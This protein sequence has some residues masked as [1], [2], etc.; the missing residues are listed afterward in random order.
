MMIYRLVLGFLLISTIAL[1][2]NTPTKEQGKTV[3][4]LAGKQRMLTQKMSKEAL[5]II[6]GIEIEKNRVYLQET[7]T[8][9]DKRLHALK[10]GNR[11]LNIPKTEDKEILN[12]LTKE[13]KLWSLFKKFLNEII[14]GKVDKKILKAV[15]MA[16]MPLLQI[17]N[18]IVHLYEKKYSTTLS[19]NLAKTINLAGRERMLIQKMTK[20]LL[21]I[22]NNIK[23]DVYIESLHRDGKLFHAKLDDLLK[24][25]AT[26]EEQK[27]T[28][29][30][31]D[32]QKLWSKYHEIIANTELSKE[33]IKKFNK[34]EKD[35]VEKMSKE[36]MEMAKIIDATRYQINLTQ[37]QRLFESTL[38][39]L[40]EGDTSMGITA[41]SDK[42][43]QKQ[44]QK[45]KK[46][47][48]EYRPTII[49]IDTSKEGL[50]NAM[51]L[52]MPLLKEMDKT[53]K[54]YELL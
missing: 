42:K 9:F 3:I 51:R 13:I 21:L 26:I 5:L 40:I 35:I 38:T 39:A 1:S 15:E 54:L 27:L 8:T 25:K 17:M 50:N 11:A 33:G 2:A 7:I 22:A 28:T 52:N 10:E 29:R 34:D 32:I 30:V 44:L 48:S 47:W 49:N 41:S 53:V 45:V 36:L 16:N 4:N 37:T 18:K 24:D 23:S 6:K 14:I 20:E 43:I 46:L 19:A 12:L 31:A